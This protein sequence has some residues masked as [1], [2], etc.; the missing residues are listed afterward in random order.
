MTTSTTTEQ[1]KTAVESDA[2]FS[3]RPELL[4]ILRHSIGLDDNGQGHDYRNHFATDPEGQ[5]GQMCQELCAAGWMKDCGAQSMW[6]GVHC[7][8]VTDHG[9]DVVRFHKPTEKILTPSQR[10]YQDFL[11]AES[12]LPFG[13]WLKMRSRI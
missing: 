9:R 10:R 7:Y 13:E 1:N 11:D 6:G 5:D 3:I 8:C 4:H 12:G 2:L